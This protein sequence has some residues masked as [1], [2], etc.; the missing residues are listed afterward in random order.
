MYA[1]AEEM[2]PREEAV[3]FLGSLFT[4][5]EIDSDH[6]DFWSLFAMHICDLYPEELMDTIKKAYQAELIWPGMVR[7]EEFETVLSEGREK[8]RAKVKKE[9]QLRS[10]DDIHGRMSW[11]ACFDQNQ[12]PPSGPPNTRRYP[13]HDRR[14]E[15]RGEGR[16]VT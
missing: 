15:R 4:G 1:E 9:L 2:M 6:S 3:S 10:F 16:D 7:Y 12:K 8:C 14:Y 5:N 13:G 11:W